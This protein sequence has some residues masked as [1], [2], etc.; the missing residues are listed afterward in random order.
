MDLQEIKYCQENFSKLPLSEKTKD[1][2]SHKTRQKLLIVIFGVTYL[3]K[4]TGSP[5]L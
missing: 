3:T 4:K 1:S 5:I 2:A